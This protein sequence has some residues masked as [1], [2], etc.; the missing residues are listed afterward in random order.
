[1][2]NT[3]QYVSVSTFHKYLN[4]IVGLKISTGK[5]YQA[6]SEGQIRAIKIG[7]DYR[8]LTNEIEDYP[9]RLLKERETGITPPFTDLLGKPVT[10]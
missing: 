5:I 7:S 3:P 9:A 1:M 6:L 8:V 4:E 2:K 10:K